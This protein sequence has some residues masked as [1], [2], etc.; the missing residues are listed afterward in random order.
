MTTKQALRE[1]VEELSE[2]DAEE[3]LQRLSREAEPEEHLTVDEAASLRDAIAE[4][5]RG[6]TVS[7]EEVFRSLGL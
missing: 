3:L 7:G 1:L 5:E 2:E 4:G 6:E